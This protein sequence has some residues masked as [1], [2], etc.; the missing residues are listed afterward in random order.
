MLQRLLDIVNAFVGFV[1]AGAG[2]AFLHAL[3]QMAR[4]RYHRA[5]IDPAYPLVQAG[6][7]SDAFNAVVV[8]ACCAMWTY[9]VQG[10]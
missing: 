9:I 1:S 2:L 4:H 10:G 6:L 8:L 5:N 3:Y 7:R